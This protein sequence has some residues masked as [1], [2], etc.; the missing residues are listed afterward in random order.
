MTQ[1]PLLTETF[2]STSDLLSQK[3]DSGQSHGRKVCRG[4]G[5]Q[6]NAPEFIERKAVVKCKACRSGDSLE[7]RAREMKE[8][9]TA[10]KQETQPITMAKFKGRRSDALSRRRRR[11]AVLKVYGGYCQCCGET[12][13]EFLAI[14]HIEGGGMNHRRALRSQNIYPW[15]IKNNYPE[16]FQVLCHNC[17]LAKGFYGA[18]PHQAMVKKLLEAA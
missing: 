2:K 13:Y 6:R 8:V 10:L 1:K 16:G 5:K 7:R 12:Q 17:N 18:C 4:C 11:D 15:L 9:L 3:G 14:D